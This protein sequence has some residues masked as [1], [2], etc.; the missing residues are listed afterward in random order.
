[1]GRKLIEKIEKSIVDGME[2]LEISLTP[3]S[4]GRLNITINIRDSC[5]D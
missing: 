5:Q 1:M 3:K 2:K 4:L